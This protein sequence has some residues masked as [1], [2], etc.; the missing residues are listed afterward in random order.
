[1][2]YQTYTTEALVCGAYDSNAADRTYLLFTRRAGMLYATARSVREE[3]SKQRYALQVFSRIT[4]SLVR[5]KSG[6]RIGSVEPLA[7]V[8][9]AASSR[10]VRGSIVTI[11]KL[12]RQY[13]HGEEP[14]ISL[15]DEVTTGLVFLAT[16][17]EDVHRTA[18][19]DFIKVRIL[20]QLGYIA[21]PSVTFT[22]MLV[23]P[24]TSIVPADVISVQQMCLG[25]LLDAKHA[26]QL[27]TS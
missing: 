5:G 7:N 18:W 24:L 16:L 19:E 23:A 9:S 11:I 2:S 6:W 15:Y 12:I 27:T 26:S 3:R 10:S 20:Y 14:Q 1:M 25:L 22:T 17:P 4:V 8:F 13:V 21:P